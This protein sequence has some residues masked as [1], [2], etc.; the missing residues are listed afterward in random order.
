MEFV[1]RTL[2]QEPQARFTFVLL[3]QP[4]WDSPRPNPDWGKVEEWLS[5]RPHTVFAGHFHRY[6]QHVRNQQQYI[7][8]A[9]TGGASR[10]RGRPGRVR[11]V[12]LVHANAEAPSL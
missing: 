7:T 10:M 6:T 4:L 5:G 8:L 2:A 12:A 3:H 1:R 11:Q 9:T